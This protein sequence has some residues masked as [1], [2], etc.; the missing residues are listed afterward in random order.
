MNPEDCGLVFLTSS[1]MLELRYFR[2]YEVLPIMKRRVKLGEFIR[3]TF[4]DGQTKDIHDRLTKKGIIPA[5][6]HIYRHPNQGGKN[7]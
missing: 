7:V 5:I 1:R 4:P 2:S 3:V 6:E